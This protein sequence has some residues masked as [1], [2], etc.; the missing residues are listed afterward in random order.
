M[1]RETRRRRTRPRA[2]S[3]TTPERK[4]PRMQE[5]SEPRLGGRR[6]S[7]RLRPRQLLVIHIRVRVTKPHTAA[8]PVDSWWFVMK[9]VDARFV[10]DAHSLVKRPATMPVTSCDFLTPSTAPVLSDEMSH[11]RF[12]AD[13]A[14]GVVAAF[15][16]RVTL[17][18]ACSS[19]PTSAFCT[20][21]AALRRPR[22]P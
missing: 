22:R 14:S 6:V 15:S 1:Y 19:R 20:A 5:G 4:S 17:P 18:S 21:H 13:N 7:L 2:P 8:P 11:A 16:S 10:D 3:R 12:F 9:S